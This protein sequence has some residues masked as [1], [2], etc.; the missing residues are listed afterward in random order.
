MLH[1]MKK[2]LFLACLLVS[3][4]AFAAGEE[5]APAVRFAPLLLEKTPTG[6]VTVSQVP[7]DSGTAPEEAAEKEEKTKEPAAVEIVRP[8]PPLLSKGQLMDAFRERQS[9]RRYLPEAELDK[10]TVGEL[11]WV[12]GGWNRPALRT[13][14]SALNRQVVSVWLLDKE[15]A[16]KYDASRH[17][18]VQRAQGDFR[19]ASGVQPF[20]ADAAVQLVYVADLERADY[21]EGLSEQDLGVTPRDRGWTFVGAEAGAMA[22][23]VS[24]YCAA[25]GLGTCVRG[26][27]RGELAGLMGIGK[28]ERIVLAQSVGIPKER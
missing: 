21:G 24:L 25:K 12:A 3:P 15:G 11:L 19:A 13:T 14:P 9:T 10:R 28:M 4:I 7:S 8:L 1:A 22:Q 27:V 23:N 26:S 18:M 5:A 2:S 17:A 6:E 16:W 20:V